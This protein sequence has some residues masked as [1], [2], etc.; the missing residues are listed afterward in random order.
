MKVKLK[1]K[2]II[3]VTALIMVIMV[4]VGYTTYRR[5]QEMITH[6]TRSSGLIMA[7]SLAERC[8]DPLIKSDFPLV[9]VYVSDTAFASGKGT[10]YVM[11]FDETGRCISHASNI[12][13][14]NFENKKLTDDITKKIISN[15]VEFNFQKIASESGSILDV[16]HIMKVGDT[17]KGG[18]RIGFN[19]SVLEEQLEATV[20]QVIMVTVAAII[21][22]M[23]VALLLGNYILKPLNELARGARIL[24]E[25]NFDHEIPIITYDEM[26]L[27]AY[28][29]NSMRNNLRLHMS[30]KEDRI[31]QLSALHSLGKVT[32]SFFDLNSLL[33]AIVSTAAEVM[34]SSKC[35]ITVI[36]D[37]T[38]ELEIRTGLGLVNEGTT[39][40]DDI[41]EHIT[42]KGGGLIN[43]YVIKKGEP[44]LVTDIKNDNRFKN[45]VPSEEYS[46]SS[47]IVVPLKV[48][49]DVIGTM[50]L[51]ERKDHARYTREDLKLVTVLA[52]Q[53]AMAIENARLHEKTMEQ[54]RIT[55][56][57]EISNHIQ[58]NML[59]THF[60]N[61]ENI[62]IA[63]SSSPAKKVGGDYYDI[64][65]LSEQ[66]TALAIGDVSG[67]GM[68]AALLMV[69]IR[70]IIQARA[71]DTID[72]REVIKKVNQII[73]LDA[74]PGMY[75]TLFY[76][77][78]NSEKGKLYYTNAG[79]N[80]PL[81]FKKNK[82][83]YI[84][85]ETT[86]MFVGMFDN[87]PYR[88][89]EVDLDTGD[90]IVFY[91]DGVTEAQNT[92]G[93]MYGLKRL[94]S[95]IEAHRDKSSS[96]VKQ[97]ILDSVDKFAIDT[98]QGDDLTLM[99]IRIL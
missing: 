62:D 35:S 68:P 91:T 12:P 13:G 30:D 25:G 84:S 31:R 90:L 37:A 1:T 20:Y 7:R 75:A 44:L 38:K 43:D 76:G 64:I 81:L 39:P 73:T 70:T 10:A 11:A 6:S 29:F 80:Y 74:E 95:V 93:E 99:V 3:F 59:P 94:C 15:S 9:N 52:S 36:N 57:L 32:A 86:G 19:L 21:L 41:I 50:S 5:E 8:T 17:L 48:K 22:G 23:I 87:P 79:H 82:Q 2:F 67:K 65:K 24:S 14:Q 4:I 92:G 60:P 49:D 63:A 85:L 88:E 34:N 61:V 45:M 47:F 66:M 53:V 71:H 33:K 28:I 69:E 18:V 77:I 89:A 26:G 27:L 46:S 58:M 16:A 78:Y 56:E 97:A 72:S 54:N 83:G 40:A 51:T 98:E 96:Q 42:P 55:R